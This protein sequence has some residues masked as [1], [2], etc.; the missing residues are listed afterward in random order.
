MNLAN[1]LT[2]SRI[3][4]IPFV[5][6][7]ILFENATNGYTIHSQILI[8]TSKYVALLIFI[9]ATLT[10]LYDGRI[11]RKR[12][13]ITPFGSFF[14]PIADKLLISTV[15]ICFVELRIMPA[16]MVVIIIGREFIITGLRILGAKKGEVI[17]A[18]PLGKYKTVSQMATAIVI[19]LYLA[20]KDTMRIYGTWNDQV[21]VWIYGAIYLL[22][23]WTVL[24]TVI[25][26]V[27]YIKR[28]RHLIRE[29]V[30]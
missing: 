19:L 21:D 24:A 10:D 22:M 14:D 29:V 13:I 5:M 26:G 6:G 1:K 16:W 4:A 17:P 28:H 12:K 25:S 11:A 15:F 9:A 30:E 2:F 23:V 7:A 3:I 8:V 18:G 27:S 20:I